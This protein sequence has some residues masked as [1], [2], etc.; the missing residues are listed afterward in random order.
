MKADRGEVD[1]RRRCQT[2]SP[3]ELSNVTYNI[4]LHMQLVRGWG[5]RVTVRV[6]FTGLLLLG[7]GSSVRLGLGLYSFA[8]LHHSH[9]PDK[10]KGYTLYVL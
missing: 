7:L 9:P 3:S 4:Q 10:A 5:Y 8:Y 1:Y 6:G 2:S